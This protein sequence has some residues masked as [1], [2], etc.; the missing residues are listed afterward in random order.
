MRPPPECDS[1]LTARHRLG[2]M[3]RMINSRT[4]FLGFSA[5]ALCAALA[6]LA[7]VLCEVPGREGRILALVSTGGLFALVV[8]AGV[9][10]VLVQGRRNN[11]LAADLERERGLDPLTRLGNRGAFLRELDD[12]TERS[13]RY[14][15]RF[16]LI[17]IDIDGLKMINEFYGRGAGDLAILTVRDVL[18]AAVRTVDAV[19]SLGSGTFAVILPN[20]DVSGGFILAERLRA[21]LE[22]VV[23]PWKE[24]RE[25]SLTVSCGLA[26]SGTSGQENADRILDRAELCLSRA[27][28]GGRNRVC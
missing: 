20:T 9:R 3:R 24:G 2:T 26:V 17:V 10:M 15:Y 28:H 7:L 22:S 8:L 18:S 25:L 16:S 19:Y 21:A 4:V 6:L 1:C 27:K 11:Q 13:Q 23:V 12:E 5:L 14:Q